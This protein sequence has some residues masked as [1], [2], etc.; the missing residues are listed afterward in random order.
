MFP[1][2]HGE[3]VIEMTLREYI[4]TIYP[5]DALIEV[6]KSD[7]I[8]AIMEN[9]D[10]P[11]DEIRMYDGVMQKVV[12][13]EDGTFIGVMELLSYTKEDVLKLKDEE[14]RN[15]YFAYMDNVVIEPVTLEYIMSSARELKKR[16]E[17]KKE[18]LERCTE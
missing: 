8:K 7:P 4:N 18:M 17:Q 6:I 2:K 14:L 1:I 13:L 12:E 5:I 3:E 10:L 16:K 9:D 11:Y 15:A